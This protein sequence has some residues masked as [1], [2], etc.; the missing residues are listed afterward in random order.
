VNSAGLSPLRS[1]LENGTTL[2][3]THTRKTPAVTIS[4]AMRGGSTSD[5]ADAPG[6]MYLLSRVIDRGT[7]RRTA[8]EIAEALESRGNTL[9]VAVNRH[10][11]GLTCTCLTEDFE[12]LLAILGE[13][14]TSPSVPDAELHTR[15][16]EVITGLRQN[17]DNPFVRAFETLLSLLYGSA[18]PYGRP[19][20]GSIDGV[21]RITREHLLA[22]HAQQFVPVALTAVFV[23]D[24]EPARALA[25]SG[26]VFGG[27]HRP[28]A[29]RLA[30]APPDQRPARRQVVIPMMNKAQADVAYGFVA[31]PRGDASYYAVSLLNNILGQYAMG[32]RLGASIREKQGLAYYCSSAFDAGH[33]AGPL[34]VRAGV[35]AENVDRVI[36]S[37][38]DELTRLRRDG[39]TSTELTDSRQYL[40]GSMPRALETNA[41]IANF[42]QTNELFDLGLDHDVRLPDLLARVTREEV[43]EAARRLLDPAHATIVVAGP[44]GPHA[45]A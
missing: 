23:G 34:V 44:T 20:R 11:C 40:I 13:I 24:I 4:L 6:S 22:L 9:S 41:G 31:I 32:G 30:L 7:A 36:R 27:W 37:V 25:V 38:D 21:D 17:E 10:V 2:V 28:Q 35:A 43:D 26:E 12:P 15:K 19:L 29:P 18:H 8:A 3:A 14:L 42:L 16:R 5:P 45:S 1:V 39:V 33:V